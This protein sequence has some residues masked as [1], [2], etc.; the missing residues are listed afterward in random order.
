MDESL[1][2]YLRICLKRKIRSSCLKE[3]RS[4]WELGNVPENMFEEEDQV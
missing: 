2:M 1:G 3:G 4:G